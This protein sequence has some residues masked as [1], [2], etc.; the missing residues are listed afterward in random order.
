MTANALNRIF[1]STPINKT[2]RAVT[3][4]K[5]CV[6]VELP[7]EREEICTILERMRRK[8]RLL[9]LVL[10]VSNKSQHRNLLARFKAG[11]VSNF[12]PSR[13]ISEYSRNGEAMQILNKRLS[14]MKADKTLVQQLGAIENAWK[15]EHQGAIWDGSKLVAPNGAVFIRAL[16]AQGVAA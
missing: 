7:I 13:A 10:Q 5:H 16:V 1:T 15:A 4:Q 2:A 9:K 12:R 3:S 11:R 6:A 8:Q 14:D